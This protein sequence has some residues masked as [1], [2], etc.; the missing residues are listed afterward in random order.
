MII[1]FEDFFSRYANSYETFDV[2][3]VAQFVNSPCLFMLKS[4][5]QLL[6]TET[7]VLAFL[8]TGLETYR[9]CGCA[10]FSNATLNARMLGPYFGEA[11]IAWTMRDTSGDAVLNFETT[12]VVAQSNENWK[13][14]SIIRHDSA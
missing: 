14:A 9:S 12:Y 2:N 4:E 6:A 5:I 3:Q 11:D 7:D 1:D 13:I 8:A 10:T